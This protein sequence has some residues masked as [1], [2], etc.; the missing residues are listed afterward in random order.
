MKVRVPHLAIHWKEVT[1]PLSERVALL[2]RRYIAMQSKKKLKRT[3][4]DMAWND[5]EITKITR[6]CGGLSE[7]IH[8]LSS[9]VLYKAGFPYRSHSV[10]M[11]FVRPMIERRFEQGWK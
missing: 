1:V 4:R 2:K 8:Y 10:W 6:Y 5:R 11:P 7:A 3:L 9:E